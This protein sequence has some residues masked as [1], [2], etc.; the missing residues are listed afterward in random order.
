MTYSLVEKGLQIWQPKTTILLKK[1]NITTYYENL[2]VEL[3]VLYVLNTHIKFCINRKL[4]T[5]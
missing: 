3:Y 5:I 4:F 1:I 2:T